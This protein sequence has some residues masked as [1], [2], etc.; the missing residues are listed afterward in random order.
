MG[1]GSFFDGKKCDF[2]KRPT[3]TIRFCNG[4]R[5]H[6]CDRER[7]NRAS[8]IKLGWED[9]AVVFTKEK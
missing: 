1:K 5:H 3:T 8:W 6:I 2:C 7:C 9:E 4:K